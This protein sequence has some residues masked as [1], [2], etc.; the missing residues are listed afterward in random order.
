M[1]NG[2]RYLAVHRSLNSPSRFHPKGGIHVCLFY[3]LLVELGN[4][5]M[6]FG[7]DSAVLLIEDGCGA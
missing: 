6:C 4:I 7:S 1:L 5:G 3:S 2:F